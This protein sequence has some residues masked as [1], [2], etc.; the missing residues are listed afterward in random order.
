MEYVKLERLWVRAHPDLDENWVY[1]RILEDPSILGLGD[2]VLD[3]MERGQPLAG[4]LD[5][6]LQDPDSNRRYEVEI[7]L[8]SSDESH[9]VRTLEYWD[10]ERRR[11]PQYDHCGVIIAEDIT[12]RFLN[13][14]TLFNEDIPLVAIQ[15]TALKVEDKV[16]LL[17]TT[18]IDE[19]TPSRSPRRRHP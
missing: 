9:I 13:V 11:Y 4:Q 18:V 15:M 14:I 7:Q 5:L 2:L 1:A 17:F 6:L 3:D 19:L 8:G 12:G 10:S 16:A